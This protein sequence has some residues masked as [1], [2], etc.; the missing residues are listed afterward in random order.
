M[1]LALAPVP[2]HSAINPAVSGSPC[3]SRASRLQPPSV[4]RGA[5]L[6]TRGSGHSRRMRPAGF[7]GKTPSRTGWTSAAVPTP[8]ANRRQCHDCSGRRGTGSGWHRMLKRLL[9]QRRQRLCH[10]REPAPARRGSKRRRGDCLLA[11]RHQPGWQVS[12]VLVRPHRRRQ[13]T[14]EHQQRRPARAGLDHPAPSP[15]SAG[16]R[17]PRV[18][19]GS[20]GAA[21]PWSARRSGPR[22]PARPRTWGRGPGRRRRCASTR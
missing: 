18:P 13:L 3:W 16:P 21:P 11:L 6:P 1:A 12:A 10:L 19:S 4:E 14:S 17:C 5:K 7:T 2:S 22:V 15:R 9:Q 20:S 8:T